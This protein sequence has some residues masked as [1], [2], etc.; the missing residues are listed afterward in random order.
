MNTFSNVPY[1]KI[2]QLGKKNANPDGGFK[3]WNTQVPRKNLHPQ[4]AIKILNIKGDIENILAAAREKH[5]VTYEGRP[6]KR[7]PNSST[8]MMYL[9]L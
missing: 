9:R 8:G 3:T 2:Y 5:Q 6:I 7:I 1:Q 4:I